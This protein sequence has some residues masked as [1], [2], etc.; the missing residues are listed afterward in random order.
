M[1]A[2]W[3]SRWELDGVDG[4]VVTLDVLRAF[5]TAAY[6]FAAGAQEIFL[7]GSVEEALAFKRE[8]RAVWAMG[9]DGG[10][11]PQGFELSNSPVQASRVDLRGRTLVQRTSAGTQGVL[12]ARHATVQW[13]ASL[14]CASATAR[15]VVASGLGTPSYVIT[16]RVFDEAGRLTQRGEEDEAAALFIE[17]ARLGQRCDH[18]EVIRQVV[19]SD[20]AHRTLQLVPEH[21]DCEDIAYATRIDAFDF[22]MQVSWSERGPRLVALRSP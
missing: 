9:E 20:A 7:V 5:T 19:E 16:G 21:A 22:A 12:A 8:Q 2:R 15:A 18:A 4:A 3:L 14:V 6:A 17:R 10:R 13:C 1:D 11:R